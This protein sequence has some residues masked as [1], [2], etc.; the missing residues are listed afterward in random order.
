LRPQLSL[1]DKAALIELS[2][3]SILHA[4]KT[5]DELALQHGEYC[6]HLSQPR[7]SF[8]TLRKEGSLRGC[9][10]SIDGPRPLAEDVA[11]NS[12]GAAL[13]DTR[14]SPL[15]EGE[16]PSIEI[17]LS[18]LGP[19]EEIQFETEEEL[20][21]QLCPPL[22]GLVLREVGTQGVFLPV[23]WQRIPDRRMFL[24]HLKQKASLPA[25]YWSDNLRAFRFR[26]DF[27]L[28]GDFG[29]A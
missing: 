24:E 28:D 18:V 23:M 21:H 22:D 11:H 10:G 29:G 3:R 5:G 9:I 20:L 2:K 8:V 26:V 17:H 13:F 15:T 25:R 1:S 6:G 4:V 16:L 14:F 19:V 27:D 12:Y 7:S